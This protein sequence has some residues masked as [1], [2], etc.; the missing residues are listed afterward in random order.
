MPVAAMAY[1]LPRGGA[2]GPTA[3]VRRAHRLWFDRADPD[4][5]DASAAAF[6]ELLD[7]EVVLIAD[8]GVRVH[9]GRRRIERLLEDARDDWDSFRYQVAEISPVA[10]M[11]ALA[12][13]QLVARPRGGGELELPFANL[14]IVHAERIVHIEA[15]PDRATGQWHANR[16]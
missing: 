15:G 6:L 5:S 14:C 10:E 8:A 12:A 7:P 13:G 2:G 16:S 11:G 4:G 1:D 3:V 9:R